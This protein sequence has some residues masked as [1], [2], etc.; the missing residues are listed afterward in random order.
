VT[1]PSPKPEVV[2]RRQR[3]LRRVQERKNRHINVIGTFFSNVLPNGIEIGRRAA[4][5]NDALSM[6]KMEAEFKGSM[7]TAHTQ[8]MTAL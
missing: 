2:L 6:F 5:V 7:K 4:A 3:Q 8:V 1:S